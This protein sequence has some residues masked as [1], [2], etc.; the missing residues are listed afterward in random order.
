MFQRSAKAAYCIVFAVFSAFPVFASPESDA[1]ERAY[2]ARWQGNWDLARQEVSGVGRDIIDWHY[3]RAGR[4]TFAEYREFL[5]RNADWPGLPLLAEKGEPVIPMDV[6]P[7][8][9]ID[10]LTAYPPQTGQGAWKLVSAYELKGLS[11]DAQA[12]AV[13]FWNTLP[14][15]AAEE[16]LFLERYADIL[17][18]HHAARAEWLLWDEDFEDAA[19]LLPYLP[20]GWGALIEA[21]QKLVRDEN[22]VDD[23]IAAIPEALSDHPVLAHARFEWRVRRGRN[24]DAINL[25]LQHSTPQGIGEA[26]AWGDRRRTLARQ[27]MRDGKAQIAYTIASRHMLAPEQDHYTDLEWLSGYLALRYLK[28]PGQALDH[29]NR[30]RMAVGTPISL[31]RAGYWEGR[32]LEEMGALDDAAAAYEF[33]AQFQTSF[34]GLLSAEK[35]GRPLDPA[36]TGEARFDD[37]QTAAFMGSSVLQA[38]LLL[39]EADELPLAARF[40]RHLGESLTPQELGQL[41]DLALDHDPYLAVLVA[42]FAADRGI[43]LNRAYYPLHELAEADLPVEPE[44]ALSIARRESEFYA[45]ARS[46]VGARGLMQLMPRTGEAMAGKLSLEG[47]TESQ[48][49]DPVTNARLGSAYLAQLI[50]E[51]GNNVPLVA[52]GYNAG[53]SRARDW[54]TRYGDPR[55]GEVDPVDWIEHLPFRETRNYVMRVAE[56]LPVYRARLHGETGPV[57]L[58]RELS[59]R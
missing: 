37:Y 58:S 11:G 9:V 12:N 26:E 4:G 38:A 51:F 57:H 35:I 48:L 8:V 59:A 22:G 24:D 10:Y 36:L 6:S 28:E 43:V 27:M 40:M 13:L 39:E 29:F 49:D 1:L 41:G 15:D 25:M 54:I 55:S 30:F 19:R 31:G 5:T 52:V 21:T 7:D 33:G 45:K 17:A 2:E 16:A 20:D 3:L 50:E 18:P 23:A 47:F 14:M 42:K 53:P 56:S 34:Y 44:L 32:A 46:H